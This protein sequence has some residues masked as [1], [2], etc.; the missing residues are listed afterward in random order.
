MSPT[1][2]RAGLDRGD[3]LNQVDFVSVHAPAGAENR[4]LISADRLKLMKPTAY[5]G[6]ARRAATSSTP[7]PW[8]GAVHRRHR[9]GGTRRPRGSR[10][11]RTWSRS[12]T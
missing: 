11:S 7:G 2:H 8:S 5:P 4:H 6:P 1:S 12:T 3:L 9:R 10:T